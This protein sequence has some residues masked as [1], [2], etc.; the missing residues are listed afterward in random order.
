M[1]GVLPEPKKVP[2]ATNCSVFPAAMLGSTGVTLMAVS[3]FTVRVAGAAVMPRAVAVIDVVPMATAV[4]TPLELMLA[5]VGVLEPQETL[6][7][8][9][10]LPLL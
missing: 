1:V 4:A 5:T 3:W 10:T 7:F 9:V 6:R 2:V 8:G